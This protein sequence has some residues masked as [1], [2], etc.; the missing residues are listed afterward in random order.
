MVL[1][2]FLLSGNRVYQ[3]PIR[4]YAAKKAEQALPRRFDSATVVGCEL[5]EASPYG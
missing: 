5:H 3:G 1:G 4:C 2:Q